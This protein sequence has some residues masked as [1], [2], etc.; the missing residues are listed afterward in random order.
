MDTCP[1]RVLLV[2]DDEDDYVITRDLLADIQGSRFALEW[3][4]TY[5]AALETIGRKQHDVCLVD[6][7]LGERNGLEFLR[8]ALGYGSKA[9]MILLTGQRD[10]DVDVEAMKAGAADYL[11]KG[12]IDAQL[13]E[14]AIRY[15][16]KHA[17]ALEALCESEERYALAALGAND[18]LWDWNLHTNEV[19]F[20]PR[21]KSMLGCAEH[22]I[23]SSPNAWFEL[24]HAEDL[25]RV[26]ADIAAHL[27]GQTLHFENEHRMLHKNGTYRWILS[28][29]LAIRDATGKASR[30]AGS[31]TDITERKQAE[32]ELAQARDTALESAQMKSEFLANMSH[33]IRTPMN[34]II[35][36]TGLLLDTG[37]T[38]EQYEF[39]ETVRSSGESLLTII[40]N[41]LDFSKIEAGK[42]TCE[43]LDFDLRITV[44]GVVELL[45]ERTLAKKLELVSLIHH[46]VPTLVRGDP[47]R[48]RQVLTNLVGNAVKF[49]GQGE[50]SVRA[51][52]EHE[53]ATHVVVRFAVQ[54]TGVG[55]S[56]AAQKRIFDAFAQADGSTTRKYGG[57][58][59]GL[60]ICRQLVDLMHG[61]I[62]VNSTP[63]RGSTFWFTVRLEKQA[64]GTVAALI[65]TPERADMRVLVVDDHASTR[66]SMRH[67][68]TAWRTRFGGAASATEAL[69]ALRHQAAAG[70][71]YDVA[72]LDMQ[73]PDMDGLTL[74]RAIKSDPTI[75]PTR[76]V[77]ASP[78]GHR[79]NEDMMQEAG[80]ATH[81]TKP[82]KQSQLL[83]RLAS[84]MAGAGK[85]TDQRLA[86]FPASPPQPLFE[87]RCKQVRI[88]LAEDDIINRKVVLRQLQT[89]GY[90]ADAVTNGIEVLEALARIPYDIVLMDC[91]MPE[92]DGYAA[93]AEIH[94]R[95]GASKRTTI[96]AMTAHALEGDR[97]KC[98]AA[99]MDDYLSKP[100]QHADL[101]A[102]LER[103]LTTTAAGK[104]R[105]TMLLAKSDAPYCQ[106]LP[107]HTSQPDS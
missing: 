69:A 50:V 64:G 83:A 66:E 93:T 19:Y 24:V 39:A 3:V 9:P 68:L 49:T 14:R 55:I 34:G 77:M 21:W 53:D 99:G 62:G 11:I 44:E 20:S 73:M 54:D 94:R 92:M 103:W 72:I 35:G 97:E 85:P 29:G 7:R 17:R 10:H 22:E 90:T 41:I 56:E 59:L 105:D 37:L 89:L 63:G 71:P 8:E 102:I 60:T 27:A 33:E 30:M 48:L 96:I 4:A 26:K 23:G 86:P 67:Q 76:L 107:A 28:R 47:G 52:K 18:G 70:A 16:I 106:L 104:L 12:Q 95:E 42:L 78:I 101:R 31:Q 61:E 65:S 25:T 91:Q 13:L 46:D 84:V 81:L 100:L 36:M 74:A 75:A 87:D 98:L 88:L 51:T 82:V 43:A 5:E 58:G 2:D 6:Y 80:I 1:V 79:A 32:V 57:T 38:A 45:A 15:A 40:N